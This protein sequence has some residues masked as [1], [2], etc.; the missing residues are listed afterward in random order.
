MSDTPLAVALTKISEYASQSNINL[1][2]QVDR[3]K[4]CARGG[5]AV[6]YRGTLR[7]QGTEVALKIPHG[8][9]ILDKSIQVLVVSISVSYADHRAESFSRGAHLV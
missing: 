1:Y 5:F 9:P 8:S 4:L 7:P 3:Y 2:G 6:V